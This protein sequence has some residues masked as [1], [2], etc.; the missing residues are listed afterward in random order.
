MKKIAVFNVRDEEIEITKK[1]SE[2]NGVELTLIEGQLSIENVH[3]C[4]G[5]D[6]LSLSQNTKVSEEVMVKLNE[7]GIK[8]IAQRSAGFDYYDLEA[9][10]RLDII[11]SNVPVYSPE[12][13][14]EF[15]IA[16]ALRLIRKLDLIDENTHQSDFRW[17]PSIRAGLLN[18]MTV[19][20]IG[21][22]HIGRITA[23]L[24]SAFGAKVL[25]YDIYQNED[26]KAFLE[27]K[28][29]I[30]DVVKEADVVTLHVP[31]TADNF[32]QF[33]YELFKN[34]KASAYLINAARGSVVDT[35]GLLKAL[36]DNLLAGAALDTYENEGLYIPKDNRENGIDDA[37][38]LETI[39]H[40][41]VVFTPHI[42]H[43]TDVSVRNI[44]NIGLDSVLEV[45]TTGDTKNRVN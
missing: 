20:V 18:E 43:Y 34:F 14:A 8:Q 28:D 27:Y 45:I 9:A 17:Q 38:F 2:K 7:F 5:F 31:A 22:G 42:A 19:G 30:E 32:H 37:L 10:K 25:A 16:S 3:L 41:K 4:E 21:T 6:G 33:N 12:S 36:D 39:N 35:E 11:I 1:W 44:M 23:K 15:T 29:S 40:D 26:A 13:I 24:F